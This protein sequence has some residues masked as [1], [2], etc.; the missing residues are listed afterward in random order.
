VAT[1]E[2]VV[3]DTQ[4]TL[5]RVETTQSRACQGCSSKGSCHITADGKRSEVLALNLAG[6]RTGDR[7]LMQ[8][9]TASLLKACF[10]LYILPVA[11]MLIGA[12]LGHWIALHLGR[13]TSV[14]SALSGFSALVLSGM[15]IRSAANRMGQRDAYKPKILRVLEPYR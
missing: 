6:A 14:I 3:I 13:D 11:C 9:E 15:A 8:I 5:A 2:G 7:I 10:L 4:D 1:E 12:I